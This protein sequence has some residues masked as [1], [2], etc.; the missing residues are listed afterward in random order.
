VPGIRASVI[1]AVALAG[2]ASER[3]QYAAA[4]ASAQARWTAACGERP[5]PASVVLEPVVSLR[6]GRIER[7]A[8]CT[9]SGQRVRLATR[10]NAPVDGLVLHE[11]GHVLGAGHLSTGVAGVMQPQ[12]S[13]AAWRPCIT[14][15]DLVAVA[16]C[17]VYRPECGE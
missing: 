9:D 15:A 13:N 6:C 1:L 11:L 2:C 16:T 8:G 10:A 7:A 3:D 5:E 12:L 17:P 14:P 4:V